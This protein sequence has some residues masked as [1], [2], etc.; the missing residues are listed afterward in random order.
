MA[1]KWDVRFILMAR[2]V[3][4]WS[5][6]PSTKTGAV[7]VRPDRSVTSVGFN[8]FPK[9]MPDDP[10]LY[11]NREEKYSR[12]VHC[13]IN[14]SI[15]SR[16]PVAGYTLYTWPFASCD[17]WPASRCSKPGSPASSGRSAPPTNWS[18]GGRRS[19]SPRSTAPRRR[20]RSWR[21]P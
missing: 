1:P 14:A 20:C 19:N 11:A 4:E 10:A 7:I 12:V 8:G 21:Y 17:R 16:E 6:D 15:H 3:S 18:A 9:N 5:K 13:E 2:F